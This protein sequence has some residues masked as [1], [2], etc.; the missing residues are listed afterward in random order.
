MEES[1]LQINIRLLRKTVRK[2]S[3][4]AVGLGVDRGT[5]NCALCYKYW[6]PWISDAGPQPCLQCPVKAQVN[7]TECRG[8]PYFAYKQCLDWHDAE[9]RLDLGELRTLAN[10]ELMFL[11]KI[12]EFH[13][14]A[15]K[16]ID[17]EV[18]S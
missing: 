16:F 15:Q 7:Q 6:N 9:E 8:T 4:I 3:L 1:E 5:D 17:R 10:K 13:I 11:Q 12:L 2:W 14:T 18:V